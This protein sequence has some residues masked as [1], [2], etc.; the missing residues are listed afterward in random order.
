MKII[1]TGGGTGGHFY[2]VIAVIESIRAIA[3][4]HK[5]V[6]MELIYMSD[7]EYDKEALFE[8][9]VR[10]VKI[11]AGKVRR[12]FS[13]LNFTDAI[14]TG[15]GIFTTLL[16]VYVDLPDVIFSKGGYAAFPVVFAARF[17]GIPLI[18]HESDSVPGKVNAWSG[19]FAKRIAIS[20][21]TA[22]N[23]FPPEKTA[24]VGNPLRKEFL[25]GTREGAKQFLGLEE[26]TP[27]ILITGGSQG[28]QAI[29]EIILDGLLELVEKYQIIHQ[30]GANNLAETKA[31]AGV[32][33]EK[34]KFKNRYH[35]FGFL[36]K[37]SLKMSYSSSDLVIA[38]AGAGTIF[39]IA[40][41]G[42]PSILIP[43]ENS[44]QDH[45]KGNA[46]DYASAGAGDVLEQTNLTFHILQSE[47]T[48]ILSNKEKLEQMKKSALAFSK[49]EAAEKIAQEI[50][51]L[52]LEHA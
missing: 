2:P 30:C 4:K 26:G 27:V 28:A 21:P 44:A 17:F 37:D 29:N 35:L 22:S 38:R 47:I 32:I 49:P 50:I 1:F 25:I 48:R 23:F 19:K 42:V 40:N 13:F 5:L 33:L 24:L 34:S 39:E 12:Y 36:N 11:S 31:R 14:K 16:K 7:S 46:Y 8:E 20:F 45:Q 10:F 15:I 41:S 18:I 6:E 52:G 43:L 9:R 3:E 51:K